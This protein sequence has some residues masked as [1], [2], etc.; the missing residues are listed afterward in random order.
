MN[1][2]NVWTRSFFFFKCLLQIKYAKHFLKSIWCENDVDLL[3]LW[4]L[5]KWGVSPDSLIAKSNS[6]FCSWL[7]RDLPVLQEANKTPLQKC[8]K[9]G[10][11]WGVITPMMSECSSGFLLY[12]NPDSFLSHE[13]PLPLAALAVWVPHQLSYGETILWAVPVL[14]QQQGCPRVSFPLAFSVLVLWWGALEML[15]HAPISQS[16][17]GPYGC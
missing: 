10:D 12:N 7:L 5:F 9:N 3:L 15:L 16:Q 1:L 6:G 4:A 2:L 11:A 17:I 14:G 8:F 13:L